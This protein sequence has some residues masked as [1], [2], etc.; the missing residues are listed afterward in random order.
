MLQKQEQSEILFLQPKKK[1]K[2]KSPNCTHM[3]IICGHPTAGSQAKPEEHQL[4][5]L[6][7]IFTGTTGLEE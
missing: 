1:K 5:N 2:K 6:S 3:E 4:E 7:V